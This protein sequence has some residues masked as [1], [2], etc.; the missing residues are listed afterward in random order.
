[1]TDKVGIAKRNFLILYSQGC[2]T[3]DNPIL[4]VNLRTRRN[5]ES[6]I[7]IYLKGLTSG[8]DISKVRVFD[9]TGIN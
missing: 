5:S 8:P 6:D 3:C 2:Q 4:K 7:Y 9:Q 1:M